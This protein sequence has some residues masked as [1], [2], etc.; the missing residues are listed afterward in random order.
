[1]L[2]V[3]EGW[4]GV[5]FRFWVG[6]LLGWVRPVGLGVASQSKVMNKLLGRGTRNN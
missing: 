3:R 5:L 2:A 1:M 6:W 4:G